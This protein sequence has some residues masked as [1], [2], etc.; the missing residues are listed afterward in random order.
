MSGEIVSTGDG[1]SLG[2]SL[3]LIEI[4]NDGWVKQSIVT[5][6]DLLT[7][8]ENWRVIGSNSPDLSARVFSLILQTLLFDYEPPSM[9]PVGTTAI[10]WSNTIPA[11]W[12]K[13]DGSGISK[14]TYPLL[15]DVFGYT[16]GGGGD[17]FVLPT[18]ASLIPMGVGGY[19]GLG[20]LKG[21]TH[22]NIAVE[23]LPP[24]THPPLSPT[25]NFF[26]QR[27][28]GIAAVN[29]GTTYGLVSSTGSTGD[30]VAMEIVPPVVGVHYIIFAG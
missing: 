24:H 23:N 25:T 27:A 15:F 14:T 4:P 5:A 18:M 19:I 8:E 29:N 30:G 6:L 26:G 3:V 21:G 1:L 9:T 10:W 7:I 16:Y 12:L 13:L 22:H 28:S 11:G 20:Q 2:V 17:I